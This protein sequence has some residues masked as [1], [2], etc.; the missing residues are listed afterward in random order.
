MAYQDLHLGRNSRVR[1][2]HNKKGG[3]ENR[4]PAMAKRQENKLV[5]NVMEFGGSHP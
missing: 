1:E 2:V 4:D 5:P 3:T